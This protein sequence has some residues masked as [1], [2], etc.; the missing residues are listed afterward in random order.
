MVKNN[1]KEQVFDKDL[2]NRWEIVIYNLP[3]YWNRKVT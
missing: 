2:I 3:A 1:K